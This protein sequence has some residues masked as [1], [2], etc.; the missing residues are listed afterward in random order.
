MIRAPDSKKNAIKEVY[1]KNKEGG[2]ALTFDTTR[3]LGIEYLTA[4]SIAH[5]VV[6]Q[7]EN[8]KLVYQGPSPDEIT[9]V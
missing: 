3:A 7:H 4:L 5:E 2:Q 8:G 1:V 6:A 9:L